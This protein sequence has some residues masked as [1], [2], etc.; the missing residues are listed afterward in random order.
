MKNDS[1]LNPLPN[2]AIMATNR[3]ALPFLLGLILH[4]A[5]PWISAY[6]LAF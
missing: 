3:W 1:L 2:K 4:P 5:T 6:M